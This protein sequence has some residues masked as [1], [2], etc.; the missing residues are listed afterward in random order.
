MVTASIIMVVKNEAKTL[1][2][3][4]RRLEEQTFRDFEVIFIDNMSTDATP[5]IVEEFQRRGKISIQ[6][7][8]REGVIGSLNNYAIDIARGNYIVFLDGDEIPVK[9]WLDEFIKCLSSGCDAC[10]GPVIYFDLDKPRSIYVRWYFNRS[11]LEILYNRQF[12]SKRI[13][14]NMGN[15]AFKAHVIKKVRFNPLLGISYDGEASYRFVKHGFKLCFA[16]KA[17]VFHPAPNELHRHISF[18]WK[19]A[20]AQRVLLSVH[21]YLDIAKIII[22]NN[23]LAHLDPREIVKS[24][25][26][27]A[28]NVFP[29]ILMHITAFLT[30]LGTHLKLSIGGTKNILGK[31][32]QRLK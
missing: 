10:L 8:R 7:E 13:V 24:N 19:L 30:L 2:L 25:L 18:W 4:F 17:Y 32:V 3:I 21:H 23:I 14:F 5:K 9:T 1:P 11:I 20:H 27:R 31:N 29:S 15:I 22:R 6:Y 12:A 16:D 26:W 28:H